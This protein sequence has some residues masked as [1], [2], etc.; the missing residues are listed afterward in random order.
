[1]AVDLVHARTGAQK[2]PDSELVF[3][4]VY[5]SEMLGAFKANYYAAGRGEKQRDVLRS[6][7]AYRSE[8]VTAGVSPLMQGGLG[9][10]R[11]FP[12]TAGIRQLRVRP[13][14][15]KAGQDPQRSRRGNCKKRI[16]H[17]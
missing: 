2:C 7:G 17:A 5:V 16:L 11:Y 4:V 9:N 12:S 14:Q 1:M 15:S 6:A 8:N 10:R 3:A 13:G